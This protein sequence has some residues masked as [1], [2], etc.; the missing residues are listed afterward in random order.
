MTK[1]A[2]VMIAIAIIPLVL[3]LSVVAAL[4]IY[5][6]KLLYPT[7]FVAQNDT[8]AAP[9]VT[10]VVVTTADGE[11]LRGYWKPPAPGGSIVITFHGNGSSVVGHAV[12]FDSPPWSTNGWGFLAIAYRGY[13]GSTGSPSEDG[14]LAD[15]EAAFAFVEKEAPGSLILFHGHSLGTG[16]AV[17]MAAKHPSKGLYLEASFDTMTAV[18]TGHYPFVPGFILRDTFRSIDRIPK[19]A[20]PIFAIHGLAD[21]I[22]PAQR[23]QTLIAAARPDAKFQSLPGVGHNNVVGMRDAEAEALF[24]S[25]PSL[26]PSGPHGRTAAT[27]PRN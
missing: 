25:L 27:T 20:S 2:R 4:A 15:G 16:I 19:V 24:R 6:R 1:T 13:P 9:G 10:R 22:I 8:W 18:A 3:W 26:Q 23:G 12:R 11:R 14:L 17:A 7:S 21:D 5:Q